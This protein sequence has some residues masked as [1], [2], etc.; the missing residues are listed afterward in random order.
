MDVNP[1]M[2]LRNGAANIEI[3]FACELRV[4]PPLQA[5][6]RCAERNGLASSLGNL[7]E[8][9]QIRHSRSGIDSP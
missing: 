7:I 2:R 8:P 9:Q 3:G 6:L 4:D 5:D 1:R